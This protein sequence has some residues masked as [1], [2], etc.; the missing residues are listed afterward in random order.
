MPDRRARQPG[1]IRPL[2]VRLLVIIAVVPLA[3]DAVASTLH[4]Y[5]AGARSISLAGS[6]D[7]DA[8]DYLATWANPANLGSTK[9]VHFGIGTHIIW[10][11]FQIDRVAGEST[12]PTALPNGLGLGHIGVSSPIGGIFNNKLGIGIH[13][14]IPMSGPTRIAARDHRTPQLAIYDSI[15]NRL[16]VIFGFGAR[17]LGWLSF[18]AG[19]Q[20]LAS[21]DGRADFALSILDRRFTQHSLHIDLFS[22]VSP[23]ASIAIHP[24]DATR[25]AIIYR[26]ESS[27]RFELPVVVDIEQVG[28]L[29]FRVQGEGLYTPDQV[30]LAA[31]HRFNAAWTAF[32]AATWARWSQLPPMAPKIDLDISDVLFAADGTDEKLIVVR[33]RPVP[34]GAKDIIVPRVGAQWRP[35]ATVSARLGLRFRPT[36]LPKA[37]GSANY[38]DAPAWT[39]ATG[40]GF[41][42]VD[43]DQKDR[44]PLAID[45]ALGWTQL[46][47][48]TVTKRDPNDPVVAT[49]L[50]GHNVRF[51]AT[52]HHDF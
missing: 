31:S 39:L 22:A 3:N 26:A 48:R 4:L 6:D 49:S 29:R 10:H 27:V 38:L 33:N 5:G 45:L 12:Y 42:L 37:D 40:L 7:A 35:N 21:L 51:A 14:H 50:H 1:A 2:I 25:I 8:R 20:L 46:Q 34:M 15:E 11:R 30:E 44:S 16:A 23:I 18:G 24:T 36:P 13:L 52:L 41:V 47:R 32:F 17:P 43:R 19:L 9:G 28:T